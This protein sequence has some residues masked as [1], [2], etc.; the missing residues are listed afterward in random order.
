LGNIHQKPL[1][2]ILDATHI[3]NFY[4][5]I[6]DHCANCKLWEMCRG[7][8]RAASEQLYGTFDRVDPIVEQTDAE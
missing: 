4:G 5:G 1:A 3:G 8:C 2:E 6:P 7:G